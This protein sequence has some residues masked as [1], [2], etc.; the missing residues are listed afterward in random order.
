[1]AVLQACNQ[2]NE[3]LQVY[4]DAFPQ[5]EFVEWVNKAWFDRVNLSAQGFW[6]VLLQLFRLEVKLP[7]GWLSKRKLDSNVVG[8]SGLL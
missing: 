3:R 2:I 4:K 6:K 5:Q 7:T 8:A 1:M